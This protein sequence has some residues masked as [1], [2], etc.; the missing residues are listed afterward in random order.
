MIP[1][2]G[3]TSPCSS[4]SSN[5]VIW[6]GPDIACIDLCNG[7][8]ISDVV[9][10]LAEKLCELLD[11]ACDCDPNLEG[12]DLK[13]VLPDQ[14]LNLELVGTLQAIID[15]ICDQN[16]KGGDLP[17]IT[18]PTCLQYSD[19]LGNIVTEL[20]LV[21]W[22]TL[23]GNTICS[24]ITDITTLNQDLIN[25]EQ[26]IVVLE[27]CVLPCTPSGPSDFD[28]TSSCLFLDNQG[29]GQTVAISTLVLALE[30]QFCE[31]RNV[32][33]TVTQINAAIVSQCLTAAS[34]TLSGSAGNYGNITGWQA[35]PSTL[36][37]I[38]QNQWIVLCD[39][40][41]A[42]TDIQNNCCDSGCDGYQVSYTH[43]VIT[44]GNGIPTS[45]EINFINSSI[46]NGFSDCSGNTITTTDQNGSSITTNFQIVPS[47][48]GAGPVTITLSNTN[49]DVYGPLTLTV[50]ACITDGSSDCTS[51]TTQ[52]VPLGAP[53]PNVINVSAT[54]SGDIGVTFTNTLGGSVTYQIDVINQQT[55]AQLGTATIN[56]PP[57]SI[58]Q[59]FS[60]GAQ[61]V[62]YEVIVSISTGGAFSS[63]PAQTVQVPGSTCIS[64][65]TTATSATKDAGA[66]Y[67][68]NDGD[69]TGEQASYKEFYFNTPLFQG[70]T[71]TIH[72]DFQG[73]P[74][75]AAPEVNTVAVSAGGT[76]TCTVV[77]SGTTY[78]LSYSTDGLI[79]TG[80]VSGGAGARSL[81][82]G[83]T[84]GSI[85]FK[86]VQDCGGGTLSAPYIIRYDF[87]TD[88]YQIMSDPEEADNLNVGQY[89]GG[90]PAG[91]FVAR[92]YLECEGTQYSA[93]GASYDAFW[94]FVGKV[95][96]QGT[97]RYLYVCWT[98]AG[99]VKVVLCCT[100][101]AFILTDN[102][103]AF[104]G[105]G[106]VK[107]I[108]LPYVL[109][110][111]SP[112][113]TISQNPASGT[114]V[115]T[116]IGTPTAPGNRITYTNLG[117]LN[118][119]YAD[120]FQVTI[121]SDVQGECSSSTYTIQVQIIPCDIGLRYNDQDIYMFV[122]TLSLGNNITTINSVNSLK[123]Q[124]AAQFGGGAPDGF[125]WTGN[126]Y[127][128][129][130]ASKRWLSYHKAVVDNGASYVQSP[131]AT[132]Q[133]IENTPASWATPGGLTSKNAA[134][135]LVISKDAST[136]Y[137]DATLA[138]GF[139]NQPT[140]EYKEDYETLSDVV[141]GTAVSVW[142]QGLGITS[143]VFDQ[144]IE[145]VLLSFTDN[146]STGADAAF[147]LQ[148]LGAYTGELIPPVKY[149]VQTAI[150]VSGFIMQGLGTANPYQGATT[151]AGTAI[152]PL[153]DI[154]YQSSSS[155][156]SRMF[157][158]LDQSTDLLTSTINPEVKDLVI[159]S[160]KGCDDQYP[161][162]AA[163]NE[164]H[165]IQYCGGEEIAFVNWSNIPGAPPNPQVGETYYSTY[166][167]PTKE[168]CYTIVALDV[169]EAATVAFD[170]ATLESDC[171]D[172]VCSVYEIHYCTG[173]TMSC[174]PGAPTPQRFFAKIATKGCGDLAIGSV[175]GLV[176]TGAPLV[177]ADGDCTWAN[178]DSRCFTVIS[179]S[180]VNA[181]NNNSEYGTCDFDSTFT[182]SGDN[183]ACENCQNALE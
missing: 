55:Q 154:G 143:P 163:P 16:N 105:E 34:P 84:S 147:I 123:L 104:C 4:I 83:Q 161:F 124:L 162:S 59:T 100:C 109:G 90:R 50:N 110:D 13:C 95:D 152:K 88:V 44:D 175:V 91:V 66:I 165:R 76:V 180:S 159:K 45:L 136:N 96:T 29:Q 181:Y 80:S 118:K 3:N 54:P 119:N 114:A 70:N 97:I 116:N 157:F 5:C 101:P 106:N 89:A 173:G 28:V 82:T 26:R 79:Y 155:A 176:N 115:L 22:A 63:C 137:H 153:F 51:S 75:C 64:S 73:T 40:Y 77:G 23:V 92:Q 49:L 19:Q 46:P 14:P 58:S 172:A 174:T 133:A 18:L 113:I 85:Y 167:K 12:L 98:S 158:L 166:G 71:G 107:K 102:F 48:S 30:T 182:A 20:P 21:D 68:G 145:H 17:D 171:D 179:C 142:A 144:G 126:F 67:I 53:C 156:D 25:L 146:Q 164:V 72:E 27:N 122:D 31:L 1:V 62:T 41:Q 135:V 33:G 141:E 139:T 131:D 86:V 148:S 24:I 127:V 87:S 121:A 138:N 108:D 52:I 37:E 42:V 35:N 7:D 38:N 103:R 132:W 151:G 183:T 47:A 60:G 61:G 120:T 125:N 93:P 74:A 10:K 99:P 32:I 150:D 39:L 81:A 112:T 78:A 117:N 169:A 149:G 111:G 170:N 94:Y 57:I 69:T 140:V 178:S 15:Y 11:A 130:T 9:A 134:W 65:E 8:T 128:L 36:A 6:Q 177:S 2:S 168:V 56:N 43:Q 129:P 160:V